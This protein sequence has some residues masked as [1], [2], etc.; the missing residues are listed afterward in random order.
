MY[1][2]NV[3]TQAGETDGFTAS[4]HVR[5]I[6]DHVGLGLIDYVVVNGGSVPEEIAARYRK[7]GA[8]PVE[9]DEAALAEM[10]LQPVVG[11][12]IDARDLVR[13]DAAKLAALVMEIVSRREAPLPLVVAGKGHGFEAR[14]RR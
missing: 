1:I 7:E 2:C 6:I 3:M 14:D 9:A 4:D 13:H 8:Y 12:V 10:G 5:A 11:D